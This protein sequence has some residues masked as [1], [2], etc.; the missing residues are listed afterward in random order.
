MEEV[1]C[2]VQSCYNLFHTHAY[3]SMPV[4]KIKYFVYQSSPVPPYLSLYDHDHSNPRMS[5]IKSSQYIQY[6]VK[7]ASL[8]LIKIF[9]GI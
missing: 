3:N 1:G 8:S 7:K 6:I 5:N 2:S 9:T 4:I